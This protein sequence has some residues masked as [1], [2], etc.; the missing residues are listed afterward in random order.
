M[1]GTWSGG[2][3]AGDPEGYIE[4]VLE[5]GISSYRGPISGTE[6]RAHLLGLLDGRRRLCG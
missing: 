4:K 1:K 2:S 6:G 5:K 3:L